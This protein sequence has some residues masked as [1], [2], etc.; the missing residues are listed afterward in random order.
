[1]LIWFIVCVI[2]DFSPLEFKRRPLP[3]LGFSPSLP[4]APSYDRRA[5]AVAVFSGSFRRGSPWSW[6][7]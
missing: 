3:L 5:E 1:M 2:L 4:W 6:T 7:E